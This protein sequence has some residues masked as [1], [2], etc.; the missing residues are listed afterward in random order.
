MIKNKKTILNKLKDDDLYYGSYGQQFLSNSDIS[1]LLKDPLSLHKEFLIS[2]A[3]LIGRL[4]HL[5]ILEEHKVKS[6]KVIDSTSRNTK[7]YKEQSQGELCLLR[8]EVDNVKSMVDKI[9]E[10]DM[11]RD[12]INP[13]NCDYEVPQ[14]TD[15]MGN[16]WKG[17]SDV[18]NHKEGLIIDLKTSADISK[19]RNSAFKYNYDSQAYIYNKLFGLDM[20]FIVID[21]TTHQIGMFDC[22]DE[23]YASGKNKVRRATEA[24]NLFYLTEGFNP[25]QYFV[26]KT[27]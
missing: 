9:Q 26:S 24:Y 19:F 11:S 17:K 14:I 27:L 12:L 10:T 22:S 13:N 2:P 1:V 16:T 21:K 5:S 20:L 25:K 23:F 18:V 4:F 6:L 3:L 7:V 8:K 15:I